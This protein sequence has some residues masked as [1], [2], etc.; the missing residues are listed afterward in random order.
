[1]A[2]PLI[3]CLGF[4]CG[5]AS[6]ARSAER[7]WNIV[8][9]IAD[10]QGHGDLGSY[11]NPVIKT[12]HVDRL[13]AEGLRFDRAFLTISSCSPSRCSILTGRYP[14]R[15]G[16]EDLH[17]P[18][19][20]GQRTLASYLRPAG[21]H[22]A[23][24]GKWHLG[25]AERRH[26]QQVIEC[27]GAETARQAV[28]LVAEL[29]PDQPCFLWIA[30]TDPHRPYQRDTI[31]EPHRPAEVT[32]PPYLPDHP[33]IR[34]ELALYY[35]EISRFDG[36]V[37]AVRA[38]LAAGGRL[39]RT[40]LVYLSDNGMP[41]PRAKTTLYDSGIRTPLVVRWPG[42]CPAGGVQPHLF[43]V[44]DLAPTLLAIAGVPQDTM[45]GRDMRNMWLDTDHA[46]RDTIFAEANWH[47]FEQFTRAARSRDFKLVR[48]Y[49]WDLP[50]W[51]S[52]DSINSQTW[53]ALLERQDSGQ[54]TAAQAWLF[55]RPRPFEELYDLR[56][57]PH[58][59]VNVID[60]PRHSQVLAELRTTLDNWRVRTRDMMPSERRRDGWTRDGNPL[61]H[62]QPWYDR[63]LKQGKR[64]QFETY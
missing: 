29:P 43:S 64:N 11:G 24:V 44:V 1:M 30:S 51:N 23:A 3:A 58:E 41:F 17:E 40:I 56:S 21:Y 38:A 48:N 32:V 13:A 9:F 33:L 36:C 49:Y 20:S 4:S 6:P 16:A 2:G 5:G 22:C 26:W 35:D 31:A 61:P 8:I 46:G 10:D 12:P 34:Q 28:G 55:Q 45:D 14:H 7:P 53:R 54:L 63:W 25:Q 18:L 19:P 50:L 59:L 27:P 57:D 47:D 15:T 42:R 60:D 37:G 52:V 62:N 39:D